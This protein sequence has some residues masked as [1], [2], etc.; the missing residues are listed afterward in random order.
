MKRSEVKITRCEKF[1][2]ERYCRLY[3]VNV[4]FEGRN[5]ASTIEGDGGRPTRKAIVDKFL[6]QLGEKYWV[7]Y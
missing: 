1:Y 6:S 3:V 2:K 7:A 5:Y 4:L